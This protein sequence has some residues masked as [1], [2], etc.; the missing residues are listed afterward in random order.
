MPSI[1]KVPVPAD[2]LLDR[3]SSM[4]GAY[5]DSHLTEI[6]GHVSVHEFIFAF[7]MTPLFKLERL[8]LWTLSLPSTDMQ[9]KQLADGTGERFGAWIVEGI[10]EHELLLCDVFRRTRSW[11]MA[12]DSDMQTRL[13]F[14]YA[15]VPKKGKTSLEFGSRMLL[16]FHGL[17]SVMLLYAAALRIS[18]RPH[19]IS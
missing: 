8:I 5:I 11:L 9:A 4:R 10:G 3:Y 7:Y 15:V 6:R 14:G 18:R 19:T 2:S 17:Y 13:Y 16:R 12:I 1:Q